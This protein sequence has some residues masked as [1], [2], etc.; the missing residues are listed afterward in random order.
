RILQRSL[1][2]N[3][4]RRVN[5]N[6]SLLSGRIVYVAALVVGLIVIL[7][8]WGTGV[9]L[10]VTLLGA[11][12]VAL[13][14]A[15]QDVLKNLVSGIYLLLE[16]PFTLG[17][18]IA[19]APYVGEVEDIEIRYTALRTADGQRVIIPNSMLFSSAV[20]N[21]SAYERRRSTFTVTVPDTGVD[22]VDQAE[23]AIR[24]AL[25]DTSGVLEQ[26]APDVIITRA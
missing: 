17:D 3:M 26:P 14:L 13:S 5:R 12:T 4:E 1:V 7:A 18:H 16:R 24:A 22:A 8:I 6:L 10:P 21:L 23:E 2:I 15:L 19:L 11:V 9:V 20:V 25:E